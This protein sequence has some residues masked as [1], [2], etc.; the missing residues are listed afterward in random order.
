MPIG[1]NVK[2]FALTLYFLLVTF[3]AAAA[4]EVG[5]YSGVSSRSM[6]TAV[7]EPQIRW[8]SGLFRRESI[9]SVR[10]EF[11]ALLYAEGDFDTAGVSLV[12]TQELIRGRNVSLSPSAL[13]TVAIG[14][15]WQRQVLG[16]FT[17]VMTS[18]GLDIGMN[19]KKVRVG[20]AALWKATALTY[21]VPGE[22]VID[23]FRGTG[24][25]P[26]AE[27][28][29]GADAGRL[30]YGISFRGAVGKSVTLKAEVLAVFTQGPFMAGF[31]GMMFGQW[32]F[33]LTVGIGLHQPIF[34]RKY[35]SQPTR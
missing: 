6:I 35:G 27:G 21:W 18:V 34:G 19:V 16:S 10:G 15:E 33:L 20:L 22:T 1:R 32:P 30:L 29:I 3:A 23:T 13:T 24:T 9:L 28:W 7:M 5:L 4:P 8:P 31:E 25:Q 2:Y 17:G 26:P 12:G 11:P 14:L